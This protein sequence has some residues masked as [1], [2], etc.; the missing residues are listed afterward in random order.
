M[1]VKELKAYSRGIDRFYEDEQ[2]RDVALKLCSRPQ[3]VVGRKAPRKHYIIFG[4][5]IENPIYKRGFSYQLALSC[6][7]PQ[8]LTC[9]FTRVKEAAERL[10]MPLKQDIIVTPADMRVLTGEWHLWP[11]LG[12][13]DDTEKPKTDVS[14]VAT[15]RGTIESHTVR[16]AFVQ[17]AQQ[18]AEPYKVKSGYQ[19]VSLL[20]GAADVTEEPYLHFS[21]TWPDFN[22]VRVVQFYTDIL[23]TAEAY[24]GA[25]G[26]WDNNVDVKTRRK[27]CLPPYLRLH[28]VF[29]GEQR[30]SGFYSTFHFSYLHF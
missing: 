25:I 11:A 1:L 23:A 24:R 6:E 17:Y 18:I 21:R 20:N 9:A 22:E 16:D 2:I 10:D 26:V 28:G 29:L 3:M 30:P 15:L 27:L 5:P 8:E 14:A 19:T 4:E 12:Y 7:P 13:G